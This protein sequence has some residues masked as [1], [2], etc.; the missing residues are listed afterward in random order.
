MI[1]KKKSR[2][3]STPNAKDALAELQ[4]LSSTKVRDGMARFGIPSANA[5]GVPVG[6]I[7]KLAKKLGT[8]HALAEALW[9]TGCYEARLLAC[10]VDDPDEVTPAQMDRWCRD[11]DNW[12]VCDTACFA[13]FDR[14]RHTFRK[15]EAWAKRTGEFQKRAAFA[16][17][18][19][20]G[21]HDK[22]ATDAEFLKCLPLIEK[23]ADDERNFVK[24]GV[25]WALRVIGRRSLKLHAAS[26]ALAQRLKM[27]PEAASRWIGND[28]YRELSNPAIVRRLQ[29]KAT[30]PKR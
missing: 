23:A 4:R 12:A 8:N 14:T 15:V 3:S 25:S 7:R 10:F 27:R 22:E 13:L 28:A 2:G 19:S 18:A 29:E 5:I 30:R 11:F 6:V 21:V 16:L 26:I 24:K 1:K 9:Q 17:L 20:A